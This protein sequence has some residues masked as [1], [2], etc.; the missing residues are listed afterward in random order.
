MQLLILDK[1]AQTLVD[2]HRDDRQDNSF[3]HRE[4]KNAEQ[5]ICVHAIDGRIYRLAQVKNHI[6][7]PSHAL[8]IKRQNDELV[9]DHGN[10]GHCNGARC[11]ADQRTL[12]GFVEPVKRDCDNDQRA[13]QDEVLQFSGACGLRLHDVNQVFDGCHGDAGPDAEDECADQD[14]RTAQV[15]FQERRHQRQRKL[16]IHENGRNR[17]EYRGVSDFHGFCDHNSNRTPSPAVL[18]RKKMTPGTLLPG[19]HK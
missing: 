10:Q 4:R 3:D 9:R 13:G 15:D 1:Y 8:D 2:Q 7:V 16:K 17:C 6:Q 12:A 11:T 18:P 5:Q 19:Y 14:H